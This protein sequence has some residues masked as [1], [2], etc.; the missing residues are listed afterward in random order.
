MQTPNIP[1]TLFI[2][3][4]ITFIIKLKSILTNLKMPGR[5]FL[6]IPFF[7]YQKKHTYEPQNTWHNFFAHPLFQKLKKVYS[8]ISK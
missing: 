2:L 3:K 6:L 5:I 7:K 8:R 4:I 1:I